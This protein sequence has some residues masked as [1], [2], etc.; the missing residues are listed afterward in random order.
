VAAGGAIPARG[1]VESKQRHRL[2]DIAPTIRALLGL[3]AD[4]EPTA[5]V[6]IDELLPLE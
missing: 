4:T 3:P 1:A 6:V 2:A 5:G